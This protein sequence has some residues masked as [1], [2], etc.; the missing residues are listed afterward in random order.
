MLV[1]VDETEHAMVDEQ[2]VDPGPNAAEGPLEGLIPA[3]DAGH[4][5]RVAGL[6]L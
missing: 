4:A 2:H 3:G 1:Q 5:T 6:R